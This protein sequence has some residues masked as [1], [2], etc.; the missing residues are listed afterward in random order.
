MVSNLDPNCVVRIPRDPLEKMVKGLIK[1]AIENT[2][3]EGNVEIAVNKKGDGVQLVVKDTGVGIV[4][5]HQRRI[6][7]GFFPT[8]EINDYSSKN[9]FYFNAGG[10]GADLLRMKIFSERYNF[11]LVMTSSRCRFIPEAGDVCPGRIS[12]CSSCRS[13]EDCYQSGGTTFEVFF[14]G[15]AQTSD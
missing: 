10:K 14:P 3:D 11:K 9:P 4:E 5:E 13:A 12:L 6:F 7:E 15:D 2:P 8:Q 1:N